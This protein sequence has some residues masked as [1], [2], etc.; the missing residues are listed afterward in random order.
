[1]RLSKYE[2]ETI[3]LTSEGDD[4]IKIY[5]F[6]VSL[7]RW[8]A[9]YAEKYP[10]LVRLD[11]WTTEG[12]VTYVLDKYMIWIAVAWFTDEVLFTKLKKKRDEGVNVQIIIDDDET[13]KKYGLNYERYFETYRMPLKGYFEN[14]VHHKF[15][16]IDLETT[17]H[18]SYNW[19]RKAQYNRETF[20][21]SESKDIAHKFA[22]EFIVLKTRKVW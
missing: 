14:I 9:E 17:L 18:G 7:K 8:L 20:E 6:N 4:T 13:N 19:T 10:H 3:I 1:M 11:R 16:V 22:D 21:I 5:T 2:K 15:C 12:S